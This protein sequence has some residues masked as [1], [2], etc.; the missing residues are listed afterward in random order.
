MDE[1]TKIVKQGYKDK[2]KSRLYGLLC[3]REKDGEWEKFLDTLL[4]ELE[5]YKS[6]RKTI[7]YYILYSKLSSCRFLSYKYYRKTL[8]ECMELFD[9]IDV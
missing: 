2:M 5:G 9:R 1:R 3:E 8:F 6:D 7:E 4:I